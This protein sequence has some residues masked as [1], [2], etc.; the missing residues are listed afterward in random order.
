MA[1][2]SRVDPDVLRVAINSA[3]EI[4]RHYPHSDTDF[5]TDV[6][7]MIAAAF[8]EFFRLG[9]PWTITL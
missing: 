5:E 7:A 8:E 3:G 2:D 4:R 1:V 6:S 9:Q